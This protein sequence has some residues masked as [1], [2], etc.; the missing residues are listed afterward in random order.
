MINRTRITVDEATRDVLDQLSTELARTPSWA[1]QLSDDIQLAVADALR[2]GEVSR[3]RTLE[4]IPASV[5]ALQAQVEQQA[6][7][8]TAM[9]TQMQALIARNEALQAASSGQ[10]VGIAGLHESVVRLDERFERQG[11]SVDRLVQGLTRLAELTTQGSSVTAEQQRELD[12]LRH[13]C[14]TMAERQAI[15]QAELAGGLQQLAITL[16][17]IRSEQAVQRDALQRLA[18]SLDSLS[19][20]WWQRIFSPSRSPKS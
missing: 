14:R 19:R 12:A 16:C 7:G 11:Q 10:A 15:G 3:A 17:D 6:D 1:L 8:F 20:P 4:P 18:S 9:G 13:D 2:E 5:R